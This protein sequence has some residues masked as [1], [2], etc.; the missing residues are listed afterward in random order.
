MTHFPKII[1]FVISLLTPIMAHAAIPSLIQQK[2]EDLLEQGRSQSA[3]DLLRSHTKS[4]PQDWFLY[5]MA[6]HKTEKLDEAE[7]A[8]RTVLQLDPSSGRA[9]LELANV[10]ADKGDWSA[11]KRLLLDVKAENPPDRVRQNIDRYLA[12]I[13]N[14]EGEY[15]GWRVRTSAGVL[16][17]SN[18]NNATTADTVTMFGLPFVLSDD[19]KAQSDMAYLLRF[20]AGHLGRISPNLAWQSNVTFSWTDYFELN[21]FDVLQLSAS[22]GP[23]FQLDPQTILSIPVLAQ[24][25]SYTDTVT[26]I[27]ESAFYSSSIGVAPQLRHQLSEELAL[28][29]NSNINWKHFIGNHERDT[30]SYSIAPGAD[31]RTC[32]QGI[33]RFGGTLG[34][35]NSGI[36]TY[37][38]DNWGMNA[39][40]FCPLGSNVAFSI[41]GSYGESEYDEREAA[42]TETRSDKRT[43]VGGNLQYAHQ[44]SGLD[45]ILGLIFIHNGSNLTL[46][47]YEKIQTTFSLRKKF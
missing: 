8:Y 35:E 14:R 32:G 23:V 27:N 18:V 34:R 28:N 46:Y 20:E 42:Y 41:Y 24:T 25:N 31:I 17:D 3:Y 19:A 47:E 12:L 11:S 44:P 7:Q 40:I 4:T 16:Y 30:F 38:N 29:F 2:S 1:L 39:S 9:K 5:A 33:F 37:S 15:A 36:N 43:T 6:A 45:A 26:A 22:T 10:L 21:A 13:N